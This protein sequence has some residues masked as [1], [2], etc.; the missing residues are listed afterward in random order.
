M[1]DDENEK[2]KQRQYDERRKTRNRIVSLEIHLDE[3]KE[4]GRKSKLV[5]TWGQH[6]N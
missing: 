3:K 2:E 1:L 5:T 6:A 4:T